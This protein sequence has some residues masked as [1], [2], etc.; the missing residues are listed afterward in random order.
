LGDGTTTDSLVPVDVSGF[1][2]EVKTIAAGYNFTC[3]VL[4]NGAVMCWG[5]ER[6]NRD[7]LITS[8]SLI[9]VEKRGFTGSVTAI[10][11]GA[12][13]MGWERICVLTA[14]GGVECWVYDYDYD[15]K[16]V[17]G[18][19]DGVTALTVGIRHACAL[20]SGG[21]VKCWGANYVNQLGNG[22]S[23]DSDIPVDVFGL[24]NGVTAIAAGSEHTCALM[25]DGGVKCWGNNTYGQKGD[26]NHSGEHL[27][28]IDVVGLES[29]VI[30]I[31]AGSANTC[32][33]MM[34]GGVKC[35]GL[36]E[37]SGFD[38]T[39]SDLPTAVD[40]LKS[41]ITA[42]AS[43]SASLYTCAVTSSGGVKCWGDNRHG[44]LGDGTTTNSSFF[45]VDVKGL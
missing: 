7:G 10:A 22:T 41:G 29:K 4:V 16:E 43:G 21:G 6:G 11:V 45:P 33:L 25:S 38:C 13:D 35:W 26:G 5:E 17:S 20:T 8:D 37:C 14:D 32:A 19:T 15:L 1:P 23:D 12:D 18:L 28:P 9:P 44:Q 40:G 31:T 27:V 24:Q 34:N 2:E 30:A 36:V 42:I 39:Y 3:A